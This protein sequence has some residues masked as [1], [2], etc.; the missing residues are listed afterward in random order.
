MYVFF[1]FLMANYISII[2]LNLML[3]SVSL[4]DTLSVVY[5]VHDYPVD[6]PV[7]KIDLNNAEGCATATLIGRSTDFFTNK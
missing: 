4:V 3:L 2:M 6:A 1:L 5:F 7:N